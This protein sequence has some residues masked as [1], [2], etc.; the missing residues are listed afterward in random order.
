MNHQ[1]AT[2]QDLVKVSHSGEFE[3]ALD[4]AVENA[5]LQ[6]Y[7]NPGRGIMVTRHDHRTFTVEL[8]PDVPY[9]TIFEQLGFGLDPRQH[10]E[11]GSWQLQETTHVQV[12][13]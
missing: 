1:S 11:A 12:S 13:I 7:N 2:Y 10:P 3:N 4:R 8:S 9:G 5:I 6:G